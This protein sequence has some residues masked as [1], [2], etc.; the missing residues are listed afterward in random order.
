[1]VD[2]QQVSLITARNS[3]NK[4]IT[5]YADDS[6]VN[7]LIGDPHAS[8]YVSQ[9]INLET[10][11]TSLEVIISAYRDESA[12]FRVLYR[13][14]GPNS[15]NSTEP[16]WEL[17]PGYTNLLDTTGDGVG[18][19][20]IDPSKNNGLPNARVRGSN[21]GEVLEYGYHVDDLSEFSGFQL[22]IVF[23]GTN[24]ARPPLFTDIRAIALA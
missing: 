2:L 16:T 6:R 17:F 18:N 5:N 22:K 21:I 14:Y 12:D 19:R 11:A 15:N 7:L 24:E 3:L 23:S 20:I 10:P 13:L 4:P 9:A 8:I 1:V